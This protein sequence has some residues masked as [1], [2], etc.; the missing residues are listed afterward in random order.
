MVFVNHKKTLLYDYAS[1]GFHEYRRVW[2]PGMGHRLSVFFEKSNVFDPYAMA[3]ARKTKANVTEIQVVGH[4]PREI[5][6]F[7]KFFCYYGGEL[8]AVVTDSKYRNHQSPW[9]DWGSLSLSK[10]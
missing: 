8:S 3:L 4:L 9:E 6:R 2:A 10:Y 5:S 7:C 1:R